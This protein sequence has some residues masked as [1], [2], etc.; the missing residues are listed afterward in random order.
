M[1]FQLAHS[2][3]TLKFVNNF[4]HVVVSSSLSYVSLFLYVICTPHKSLDL[5][6]I[7]YIILYLDLDC[8]LHKNHLEKEIPRCTFCCSVSKRVMSAS[9]QNHDLEYGM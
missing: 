8:N 7:I 6:R 4:L 2:Y 5:S 9:Q 1:I 3:F